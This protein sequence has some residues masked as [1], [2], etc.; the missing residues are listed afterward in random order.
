MKLVNMTPKL[1]W[2]SNNNRW[3]IYSENGRFT[4]D[5]LF[6]QYVFFPVVDHNGNIEFPNSSEIPKYVKVRFSKI[7]KENSQS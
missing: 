6:T 4:I 3:Q 2:E 1:L 5:D 7:I